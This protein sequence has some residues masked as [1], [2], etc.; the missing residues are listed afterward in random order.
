MIVRSSLANLIN[1][2]SRPTIGA[3]YLVFSSLANCWPLLLPS[4][5]LSFFLSFDAPRSSACIL[6]HFSPATCLE[7]STPRPLLYQRRHTRPRPSP[8]CA[9][10]APRRY[11]LRREVGSTRL[12]PR[13]VAIPHTRE[14]I[15]CRCRRA[16]EHHLW[17]GERPGTGHEGLLGEH[18]AIRK[19]IK[20]RRRS[21]PKSPKSFRN[22]LAIVLPRN[23]SLVQEH[24]SSVSPCPFARVL[25]TR[26]IRL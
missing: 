20:N 8:S 7:T 17:I 18:C 13:H 23:Q 4:A 24:P 26:R 19:V 2:L 15:P 3:L 9:T 25:R 10:A 6:C 14:T 12:T 1:L 21:G 5:Y 22:R 16:F 11:P